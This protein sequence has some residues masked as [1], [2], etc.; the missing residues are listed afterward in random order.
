M[1]LIHIHSDEENQDFHSI[2]D[3]PESGIPSFNFGAI[4]KTHEASTD[5]LVTKKALEKQKELKEESKKVA[6]D[7]KEQ[8]A[9][10]IAAGYGE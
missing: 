6:E 4:Q 5:Y 3:A 8:E 7:M 9:L 1:F 10:V 2:D